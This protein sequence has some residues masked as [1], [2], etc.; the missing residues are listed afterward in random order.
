MVDLNKQKH[1][2]FL[3]LK[4]RRKPKQHISNASVEVAAAAFES[5]VD[6][7]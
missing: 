5:L 3:Q 7:V 4:G 6:V 2:P 1:L